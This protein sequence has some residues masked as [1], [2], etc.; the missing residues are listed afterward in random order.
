MVQ[1][2]ISQ[3]TDSNNTG[4]GIGHQQDTGTVV[5]SGCLT[6]VPLVVVTM[7]DLLKFSKSINPEIPPHLSQ[8]KD[9]AH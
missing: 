5:A 7:Q 9:R 4:P 2:N 3:E 1:P 8:R 6:F